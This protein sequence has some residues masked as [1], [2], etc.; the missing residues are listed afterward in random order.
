MSMYRV[1]NVIIIFLSVLLT[2]K[3]LARPRHR[4]ARFP[5]IPVFKKM[6]RIDSD[7]HDSMIQQFFFS[8]SSIRDTQKMRLNNDSQ[9]TDDSG[10]S[11]YSFGISNNQLFNN[12]HLNAMMTLLSGIYAGGQYD[13]LKWKS[14]FFAVGGL[15][16]LPTKLTKGVGGQITVFQ[17][18]IDIRNHKVSTFISAQYRNQVRNYFHSNCFCECTNSE[19]NDQYNDIIINEENVDLIL[20]FN[21]GDFELSQAQTVSFN[22][23]IGRSKIISSKIESEL[24][25]PSNYYHEREATILMFGINL[26]L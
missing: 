15:I 16:A 3:V 23:S 13:F 14:G 22:A 1:K 8:T 26:N 6:K 12:F 19:F 7:S 25:P 21:L 20:G 10:D 5:Y 4:D 17:D 24:Y 2:S 18:L 11:N 9:Y